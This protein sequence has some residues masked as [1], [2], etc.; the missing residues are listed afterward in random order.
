MHRHE[1]EK[2][3]KK[4]AKNKTK[5][6]MLRCTRAFTF[7]TD[8]KKIE[9]IHDQKSKN[10][11][12]KLCR[13]LIE[14]A[15]TQWVMKAFGFLKTTTETLVEFLNREFESQSGLPRVQFLVGP[16]ESMEIL[17]TRTE[18]KRGFFTTV[19][20]RL[21]TSAYVF[22]YTFGRVSSDRNDETIASSA[23][24]ES[25]KRGIVSVRAQDRYQLRFCV[26]GP[27]PFSP[28]GQ[29]LTC[30]LVSTFFDHRLLTLET[31][32][33]VETIELFEPNVQTDA[34][35]QQAIRDMGLQRAPL[36]VFHATVGVSTDR[37][38]RQSTLVETR[39][40]SIQKGTA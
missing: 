38:F 24:M 11:S 37:V 15:I 3:I 34:A 21:S 10:R 5:K 4:K 32:G 6:K 40:I 18:P 14:H 23:V 31:S 35:A 26:L 22:A 28:E 33:G 30:G 8:L 20:D 27:T 2:K 36:Y 29:A 7:K 16:P 19:T 1:I 25:G 9:K 17:K 13:Q 12:E 39:E